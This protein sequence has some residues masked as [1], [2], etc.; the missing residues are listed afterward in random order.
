[1]GVGEARVAV[2]HIMLHAKLLDV[3]AGPAEPASPSFDWRRFGQLMLL[4]AGTGTM[5]LM[6]ALWGRFLLL[7][8][9]DIYNGGA[10]P[11]H[12]F[13]LYAHVTTIGFSVMGVLG[14]LS[15]RLA[16]DK[17]VVREMVLIWCLVVR[18]MVLV[19]CLAMLC[20]AILCHTTLS[21]YTGY[22]CA[23]V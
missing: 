11:W 19:W 6:A 8:G 7:Y 3:E 15:W 18:E 22:I 14:W 2:N 5:C 9:E 20:N 13:A 21:T 4:S 23:Q 12:A 1:M 10:F 16:I 17:L